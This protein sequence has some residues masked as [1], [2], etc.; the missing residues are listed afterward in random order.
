MNR[1]MKKKTLSH[2]VSFDVGRQHS[3]S[4]QREDSKDD[5]ERAEELNQVGNA[6]REAQDHRHDTEP[7]GRS[8]AF[9]SGRD[10]ARGPGAGLT[11][12]HRWRNCDSGILL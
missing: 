3:G 9:S 10:L 6:Q 2:H 1:M 4:L 8:L 7:G 5:Q 11:I 12:A